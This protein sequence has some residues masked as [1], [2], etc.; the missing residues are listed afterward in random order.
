MK[1][2]E[3]ILLIAAGIS[4]CLSFARVV[5]FRVSHPITA[6]LLCALFLVRG[7]K[8]YNQGKEKDMK[9]CLVAAAVSFLGVI[10]T[11]R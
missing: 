1:I 11:I 8:A 2:I 4:T 10:Q 3:I 9:L 6:G 7:L 5:P